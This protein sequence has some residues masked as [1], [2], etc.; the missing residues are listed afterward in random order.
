VR[1]IRIAP[2]IAERGFFNGLLLFYVVFRNN[3]PTIFFRRLFYLRLGI[4]DKIAEKATLIKIKVTRTLKKKFLL[5][6]FE[7]I[8]VFIFSSPV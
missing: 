8:I 2:G 6:I 1:T 3:I 4:T 7:N 5:F